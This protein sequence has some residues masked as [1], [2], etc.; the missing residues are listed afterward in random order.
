LND[1]EHHAGRARVDGAA[2]ASQHQ[3]KDAA[4]RKAR[5]C[6]DHFAGRLGVALADAMSE[7]ADVELAGDAGIL[8]DSG[9]AFLS[10][11]GIDTA[12]LLAR[13][14]TTASIARN[15]GFVRIR[16]RPPRCAEF[17]GGG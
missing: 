13:R 15:G 4:L 7:R 16:W 17:P 1:R 2:P 6:Y 5:T 12:P 3:Q 11:L 9:I 10:E 14:G 8:T